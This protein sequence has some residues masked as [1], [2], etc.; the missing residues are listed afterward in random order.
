[1]ATTSI[2]QL[3]RYFNLV[4]KHRRRKRVLCIGDSWFQY[5]LRRY[6]DIQ[7][8]LARSFGGVAEF[9][10]DS[11]PGRDAA[12]VPGHINRWRGVAADLAQRLDR[13][14]DLIV[15]SLGGNDV[16]GKDFARHLKSVDD[17][18]L[19]IDWPWG[20]PMPQ[21]ARDHIRMDELARTFLTIERSWRSILKLRDDF[22]P[23]ANIIGHTYGDVTPMDGAYQFLGLRSGPWLWAPMVSADVGLLDPVRQRELSRWL[24]QCFSELLGSLA[25]EGPGL[26]ILDTRVD[27]E[28]AAL[29]D[30]EIHPTRDGFEFLVRERWVPAVHAALGMH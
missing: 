6:G 14:L 10:D 27:L 20:T 18:A 23:D 13:P 29:W 7:T 19:P 30:N 3:R 22:A 4:V 16:I 12:E 1:M 2:N 28:D 5:P 17:A 8:G 25:A 21:V 15:L 9:L 24:L 11:Y 26:V